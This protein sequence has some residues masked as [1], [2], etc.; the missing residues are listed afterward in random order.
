MSPGPLDDLPGSV[1]SHLQ[2]SFDQ[3]RLPSPPVPTSERLPISAQDFD[4]S[5][6]SRVSLQHTCQPHYFLPPRYAYPVIPVMFYRARRLAARAQSVPLDWQC[7]LTS[8][9]RVGEGTER[10]IIPDR[11]RKRGHSFPASSTAT[12]AY[13]ATTYTHAS[14]LSVKIYPPSVS[15]QSC[16]PQTSVGRRYVLLLRE[17]ID[18]LRGV[19]VSQSVLFVLPKMADFLAGVV[20]YAADP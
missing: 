4:S 5:N 9:A 11:L 6:I 13:H 2:T 12:R 7:V 10:P 20:L 1:H 16:A 17:V 18:T 14:I 19:G 15:S 8:C 3:F